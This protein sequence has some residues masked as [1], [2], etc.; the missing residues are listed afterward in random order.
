MSF[1]SK[2]VNIVSNIVSNVARS[3]RTRRSINNSDPNQSPL[4]SADSMI[5]RHQR[6]RTNAIDDIEPYLKMV[7]KLTKQPPVG[8]AAALELGC[9]GGEE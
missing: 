2:V 1:S 7:E 4:A 3:P 6:A 5:A 9:W 8:I